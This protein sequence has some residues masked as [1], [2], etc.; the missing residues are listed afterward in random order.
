MHVLI[1]A[2]RVPAFSGGTVV[3]LRRTDDE[4]YWRFWRR[5]WTRRE[6]VIVV[7]HD[8]TP[9]PEALADL[10]ACPGGW[11]AQPYPYINGGSYTGLGCVKFTSA[12][13]G[14][15]PDLWDR[16]AAMSDSSHPPRHW[17]RLD[18]WSQQ[19]L[20]GLGHRRCNHRIKVGHT[21]HGG[22]SHGCC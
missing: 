11:C 1:P 13:M 5:V 16:V 19:I 4:A 20:Q 2:T 12:L 3:H 8:I 9:T 7:E 21:P 22:S 15:V 17:C 6:T 14:A 10:E 18:A